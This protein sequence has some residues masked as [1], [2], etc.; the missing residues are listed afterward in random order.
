MLE[1]YEHNCLLGQKMAENFEISHMILHY[2]SNYTIYLSMYDDFLQNR[3]ILPLL[4]M[5]T[6]RLIKSNVAI[7]K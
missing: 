6:K 1:N 4:M 2:L 3:F 7:H 5:L